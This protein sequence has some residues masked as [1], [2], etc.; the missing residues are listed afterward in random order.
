MAIPDFQ[1]LMLPLLRHCADGG[2][3][4]TRDVVPA[5]AKEFELTED[6]LLELLPNVRQGRFYNR[7]GWAK[8]YLK[9]AGLLEITGRGIFRITPRGKDVLNSNPDHINIKFLQQFSE[10]A[11]FREGDAS[12][13]EGKEPEKLAESSTTPEELLESGY[14]TIRTALAADLL[15]KIKSCS[16]YFFERLVVELLVKMGY[17]GNL[18]DAGKVTGKGSDEGIDGIINEDK[19]GLDVIYI[20]AKKWEG[21]VSR[22]EIQKFAGALLGQK[23]K[24]GVFIT[25]SAFTNEA[26]EFVARLDSKIVLIDGEQLAQLM[27]DYNLGVSTVSTYEIKRIDSDYFSEE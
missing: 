10:F 25:T 26:R 17:G 8:S 21:T 6:E 27:I 1:T 22:P 24:K 7:I 5:L 16:S 19:L 13:G 14:R 9:Q 3:H 2:E 23:A 18:K 4:A 11:A 15:Q 12:A 20:Q